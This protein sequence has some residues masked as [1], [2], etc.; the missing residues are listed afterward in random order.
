M[1]ESSRGYVINGCVSHKLF[2]SLNDDVQL[3]N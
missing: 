1:H 2:D 3:R